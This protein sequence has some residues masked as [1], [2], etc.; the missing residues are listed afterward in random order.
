[1]IIENLVCFTF[2]QLSH[3][4]RIRVAIMRLFGLDYIKKNDGGRFAISQF[5][6]QPRL[7]LTPP[8]SSSRKRPII[9]TY[10]AAVQ[11]L[12]IELSDVDKVALYKQI[13]QSHKG[14]IRE[15]FIILND[16]ERALYQAAKATASGPSS[17]SA[18]AT[19]PTPGSSSG[20][21]SGSGSASALFPSSFSTSGTSSAP[22]LMDSSSTVTNGKKRLLDDWSEESPNKTRYKKN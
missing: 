5:E 8:P 22:E 9:F 19:G 3:G 10:V 18:S 20:S 16:D 6:S 15:T 4:S 17:G 14:I 11:Q 1:M 2:F 7:T 21:G 12:K 13:G